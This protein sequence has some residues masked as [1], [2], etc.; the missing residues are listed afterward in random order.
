MLKGVRVTLGVVF[1]YAKRSLAECVT[2]LIKQVRTLN[3]KLGCLFLDRGFASIDV[4]RCL[5][6]RRIPALIACPIRGK[7]N[8]TKA[9]CKGRQSY[10]TKHTFQS[11]AQGN[12]TVMVAVVR[13]FTQ[14]GQ[15]GQRKRRHARWF[16]Y[17]LIGLTLS[18][19]AVHAR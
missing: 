8:G 2:R 14:T 15:R 10:S 16:L 17:V 1:V 6:R 7:D 3:I 9:L 13:A 19:Q 12:C 11:A 4:Y 18:P 5:Q